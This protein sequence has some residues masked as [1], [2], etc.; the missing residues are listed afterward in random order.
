[1]SGFFSI[2][3]IVEVPLYAGHY[4]LFSWPCG[5]PALHL[6]PDKLQSAV[7]VQG[8]FNR[9]KCG[10][11]HEHYNGASYLVKKTMFKPETNLCRQ[12]CMYGRV[13]N[14]IRQVVEAIA[15]LHD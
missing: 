13:S 3:P 15:G 14:V 4:L 2:W 5:Y 7:D 12:L 9:N 11:I 6:G 1:M 10:D 8:K